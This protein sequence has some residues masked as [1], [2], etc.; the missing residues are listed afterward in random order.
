M[1][2]AIVLGVLVAVVVPLEVN[3]QSTLRIGMQDDP[4]VLDP[5]QG[6]TFAGRIVFTA[7]C[8]KLLDLDPS[9]AFV[10]QLATSWAWAPD[11][12]SLRRCCRDRLGGV[13][14]LAGVA[15]WSLS[16]PGCHLAV[17]GQFGTG[18]IKS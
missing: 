5:A 15:G 11:G 3:A 16:V 13:R 4:D 18:R 10:P 8:D 9:L 1:R 6:G 7:A 17:V 14:A 2:F 12:L